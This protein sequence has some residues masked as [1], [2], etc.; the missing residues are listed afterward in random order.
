[1]KR[2]LLGIVTASAVLAQAPAF[3]VAS[4]KPSAVVPFGQNI[5]I[6]LGATHHNELELTNTNLCEM[7][8]FAHRLVSD[9]QVAGPDW[10]K[11]REVRFDVVAKGPIGA[12]RDQLLEMLQTLLDERFRIAKHN[13]PRVV[14]HYELVI[15]KGGLKIHPSKPDARDDLKYRR[16][17]LASQWM[18]MS[19][20][21][22]LLSRQLRQAVID[23]T[24]LTG[25]YDIDIEW[26]PRRAERRTAR[27]ARPVDLQRHPGST[28]TETGMAQKPDG[29]Y[30]HR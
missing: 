12:T 28:R 15:A 6:N 3:E 22:M 14:P 18:P 23:K 30:G 27:S 5:N 20:F 21:T 26:T 2:I 9:D 13:E 19:Q 25:A 10:I 1:M 11:D 4:L 29:G 7:L 17:G 8:R 24:C 16:G